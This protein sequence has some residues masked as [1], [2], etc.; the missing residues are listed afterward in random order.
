MGRH[1]KHDEQIIELRK[2]GLSCR[3]TAERIGVPTY[4]VY[5]CMKKN[6]MAGKYRSNAKSRSQAKSSRKPPFSILILGNNEV[7]KVLPTSKEQFSRLLKLLQRE[8][9]EVI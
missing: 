5:N 3:E 7:M 2:Q 8:G 9:G 4:V 6:K 1:A